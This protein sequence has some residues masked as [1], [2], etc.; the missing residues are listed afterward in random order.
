MTTPLL[1]DDELEAL[2]LT[3]KLANALHRICCP[4]GST[5]PHDWN[6]V[7][8]HIHGIQHTILSQAAARAYPDRFRLLGILFDS[9]SPTGSPG[10][11]PPRGIKR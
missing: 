1:T 6:E 4:P 2:D 3:A 5:Y 8:H 9:G 10:G 7:A 11:I